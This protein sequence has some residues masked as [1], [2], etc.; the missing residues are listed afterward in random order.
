MVSYVEANT[1]LCLMS[2]SQYLFDQ[3][4]K[5][6]EE[7]ICECYKTIL[8]F[9]ICR[10]KMKPW[11]NYLKIG[12]IYSIKTSNSKN[13]RNRGTWVAQLDKHPTLNLGSGHEIKLYI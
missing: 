11:E 7:I 9:Q 13:I 10:Q 4:L 1:D 5:E 8:V 2:Y 12:H 3:K 6:K